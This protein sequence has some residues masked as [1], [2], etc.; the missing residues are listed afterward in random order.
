[1]AA[2]DVASLGEAYDVTSSGEVLSYLKSLGPKHGNKYI[3]DRMAPPRRLSLTTRGDGYVQVTVYGRKQYLHRVVWEAFNGNIPVGLQIRHLDGNKKNNTLSNLAVG[4]QSDNEYDKY[5]TG[6]MPHGESHPDSLLNDWIVI[7]AREMYAEM[8]SLKEIIAILG[9]RCS[10]ASLSDAILGRTWKHLPN[11][12]VAR[13]RTSISWRKRLMQ[14]RTT[15]RR[16]H[17]QH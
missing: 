4:T 17:E 6:T 9:A 3:V 13:G 15:T 8:F 10:E 1:M 12:Q 14:A 5:T 2:T 11:K 7:N 16:K